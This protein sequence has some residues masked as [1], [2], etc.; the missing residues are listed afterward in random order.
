MNATIH[1]EAEL[2]ENAQNK[3]N[4]QLFRKEY[5]DFLQNYLFPLLGNDRVKLTEVNY[6]KKHRHFVIEQTDDI[7]YFFAGNKCYFQTT[8]S[9]HLE[10]NT[11]NMAIAKN[12]VKSFLMHCSYA[13]GNNFKP[14]NCYTTTIAKEKAWKMAIQEGI[15]RWIFGKSS[16]ETTSKFFD[17]L[18]KWAVKTYEGKHV[19]LGFIVNPS[20]SDP[21]ILP[22]N[23]LQS[24]LEDDSSAVLSDC[25]HSVMEIDKDCNLINY[26]SITKNVTEIKAC[27]LNNNVPIRFLHTTQQFVPNNSGHS[28][29]E[30][31][32]IFLLSNGDILIVKNGSTKFVKRN[33]QWLS[34][35]SSAFIAS[36]GFKKQ[37]RNK[38][39]RQLLENVY[40][41]V[42]DVSFSHS[43]GLIAVVDKNKIATLEELKV[44]NP[45]ND[46]S[47]NE[48]AAQAKSK[49]LEFDSPKEDQK[50]RRKLMSTLL[51]D[52]SFSN[53]DRKLRSELIALDGACIIGTDGK[54]YACGV[55]IQ[56]DSGSSTGGR[57]SAA[58]KLSKYGV[59]IKISTD[60]Y[61]EVYKNDRLVYSIK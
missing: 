25:I 31:V 6:T 57:S 24:F 13:Y 32:G 7:I 8:A 14:Q 52:T 11:D 45:Y 4:E 3:S 26:L 40:A 29:A 22:F 61:I 37:K 46:L 39:F 36:L 2:S 33:L 5:K 38:V 55:I 35:N 15:A 21:V 16:N 43:G 28:G 18:E 34:M 44:L 50:I 41:S 54:I 1:K 20:A 56:N 59:A 48:S 42:L 27:A 19:T 10:K 30:K 58:K 47:L 60:G 9:L 12:I 17:I 49:Q 51:K 53:T 23:E